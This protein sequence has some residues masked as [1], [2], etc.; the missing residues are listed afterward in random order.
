MSSRAATV[1]CTCTTKGKVG[2]T[3][4]VT[5][6]LPSKEGLDRVAK[7]AAQTPHSRPSYDG[8]YTPYFIGGHGNE[9][10]GTFTVPDDCI[11]IV[12]EQ[13]GVSTK[14]M[15]LQ[16]LCQ[17]GIDVLSNPL[18][19][20]PALIGALGSLMIYRPGDECPSFSYM[21]S[22]CFP[23]FCYKSVSG[24]VNLKRL[25]HDK[26][27]STD[28]VYFDNSNRDPEYQKKYISDLYKYSIY[29]TQI[30][31]N[32]LSLKPTIQQTVSDSLS[33]IEITQEDLCS[34]RWTGYRVYY[35]FVCRFTNTLNE[36]KLKEKGIFESLTGQ[37]TQR[38]LLPIEKQRI[39]ESLQRKEFLRNTYASTKPNLTAYP[40]KLLYTQQDILNIFGKSS[41]PELI[42]LFNTN[43]GIISK[44]YIIERQYNNK[45]IYYYIRDIALDPVGVF[46]ATDKGVIQYYP[47]YNENTVYRLFGVTNTFDLLYV[48]SPIRGEDPVLIITNTIEKP[49]TYYIKKVTYPF[50]NNLPMSIAVGK[51]VQSSSFFSGV[52]IKYY[53]ENNKVDEPGKKEVLAEFGVK[54]SKDLIDKYNSQMNKIGHE[55]IQD[56]DTFKIINPDN[57]TVGRFMYEN[58]DYMYTNV[59][60]PRLEYLQGGRRTTRKRRST[61][62]RRTR[63]YK[64]NL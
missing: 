30:Q 49:D 46:I 36:E 37:T 2:C 55:I 3:C 31:I 22:T 47:I 18:Q 58:G 9:G 8:A 25:L 43:P 64:K 11:V 40:D 34:R 41:I 59:T 51:F 39:G 15:Y 5:R 26:I 19:H 16:Q 53:N 52:T 29:P 20:I 60:P 50:L 33:T 24:I 42:T 48:H 7:L 61:Q 12:K 44:G 10:K 17:L 35:N 28:R 57:L 32:T 13:P 21:L 1:D 23:G 6:I 54:T 14:K 27:C 45:Q 4:H 38:D 62:R 56:N 63:N